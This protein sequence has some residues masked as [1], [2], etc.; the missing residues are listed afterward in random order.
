MSE[1]V[2]I[3]MALEPGQLDIENIKQN[4]RIPYAQTAVEPKYRT[5]TVV[6]K[7]FEKKR[8]KSFNEIENS[9]G[10][11]GS[12]FFSSIVSTFLFIFI[13]SLFFEIFIS[14]FLF[15]FFFFLFVLFL[16]LFLDELL[17]IVGYIIFCFVCT[18]NIQCRSPNC[19]FQHFLQNLQ[20]SMDEAFAYYNVFAECD[21]LFHQ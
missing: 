21:F 16:F 20:T 4:R 5:R 17:R 11:S 15:S 9:D 6:K 13:F 19:D 8:V 14:S 3:E 1:A 10:L 12:K 2:S 7:V 18:R